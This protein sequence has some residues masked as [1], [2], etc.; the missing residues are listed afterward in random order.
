MW[1]HARLHE[2]IPSIITRAYMVASA[3]VPLMECA[4]ERCERRTPGDPVA[5]GFADYLRKHIPEEVGHDE[6]CLDDLEVLGVPRDEVAR[7]YPYPSIVNMLG[8]QYYWVRHRHPIAFAGYLAI[9][10]G[11]PA[12][13]E[14]IRQIQR[15]TGLPAEAFRTLL[16]HADHDGDHTQELDEVLDGLPLSDDQLGLIGINIAHT[17]SLLARSVYEMIKAFEARVAATPEKIA[18]SA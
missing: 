8:M 18:G 12:S 17:N 9:I 5:A 4:L 10:E 6:D 15:D 2:M 3:S 14:R 11:H 13:A 7:Q 1:E 16:W